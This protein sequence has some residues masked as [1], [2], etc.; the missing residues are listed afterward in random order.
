MNRKTGCMLLCLALLA[1]I[2]ITPNNR[3][4][5]ADG[6]AYEYEGYIYDYWGNSQKTPSAFTL[7]TMID[8]GSLTGFSFGS[9]DDVC[10]SRDGRIFLCDKTN[11]RVNIFDSNGLFLQS[12]KVLKVG[13]G[14]IALNPDGT[15]VTLV[16]PSGAWFHEKTNEL[17]IADSTNK[18]VYV[19]DGTT[20]Y[21]TRTITAPEDMTGVT[22]YAPSKVTVDNAGRI[23]IVVASS[24]EGIVE[25]N[26][27][28][29]FSGYF[30]V[31]EPRI[32]LVQYFWKSIATDTQK[33]KMGKTYAPGF[34]NVALD[35]EGFVYA[36]TKETAAST[37]LFRLNSNGENV[38]RSEGFDLIGDLKTMRTESGESCFIDVSVTDYGVAAV[39]DETRGRIF[40]YDFDGNIL[41]VFGGYGYSKGQF[42]KP[43]SLCWLG[44]NLIVTDTELKCAY[45]LTPTKFGLAALNASEEYYNGRWENATKYF[46][47][48]ISLNAN[49][50]VAYVGLGKNL[51]MQ[52][53]FEDAM[54]YFKLGNARDYYSKAYNGYRGEQIRSH[55]WVIAL[56]F[57]TLITLLV[58]S[59]VRYHKKNRKGGD[60]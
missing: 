13:E 10:T 17:Y 43:T 24:Y 59:E 34:T 27:D 47:E 11:G 31:N 14:K 3:T 18:N 9:I 49:Y 50:E 2:F 51:L 54:Y 53:K 40:L 57:V 55:F 15:Q 42:R 19:L 4:Y 38:I 41:N 23:Y 46:E 1:G 12:V 37:K 16:S 21:L 45:I 6:T 20:Y 39:L 26:E 22:E 44:N 60:E 58:W 52:D 33:E 32:N 36:V 56:V 29:T 25:L 7:A 35:S 48:C 28:G 30:G 8:D 5:A